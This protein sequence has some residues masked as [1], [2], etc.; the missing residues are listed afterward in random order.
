MIAG[1]VLLHE[2]ETMNGLEI[3]AEVAPLI[4]GLVIM[5]AL[6]ESGIEHLVVLTLKEFGTHI[7]GELRALIVKW[8]AASLGIL[9]CGIFGIDILSTALRLLDVVP[10]YPVL[11]HW[12]GVFSTGFLMAR[13]AQAIHD[14]AVTYLGL[15]GGRLPPIYQDDRP[16]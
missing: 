1:G 2:E 9:G 14:F 5:A 13:G 12:F 4:I 3:L 7:G 10:D 8:L 15:D 6:M 16:E 11:A